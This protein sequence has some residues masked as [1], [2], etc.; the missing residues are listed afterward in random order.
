MK[1]RWLLAMLVTGV[2]AVGALGGTVLAQEATIDS[3]KSGIFGRV[4]EILGLS[5]DEVKDAFDQA[6]TEL[7]NER[8][9]AKFDEI[10]ASGKMTEE[11][12]A[13]LREWL[14]ARPEIDGASK[15]NFESK[16]HHRFGR[17]DGHNSFMFQLKHGGGKLPKFESLLP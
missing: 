11:E 9:D 10:V 1:R 14:D 4:A 5:K 17:R 7:K 13:E 8:I 3:G 2:M 12:A 6:K 16:K 15:R